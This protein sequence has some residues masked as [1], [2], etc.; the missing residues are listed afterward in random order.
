MGGRASAPR[1]VLLAA[2]SLVVAC[3]S[4]ERQLDKANAR[5]HAGDAKGALAAYKLL[6][7]DLGEGPLPSGD[8]EVR[9][10][11]LRFAGDVSY[12]ELG[13]YQAALSYYRRVVSLAPGGSKEAQE[14]RAVL[15][16]IYRERFKDHLAAIAQYAAI[17]TSDSASAP[18]YQLEVSRGYLA[19]GRFDQAR[20]EARI[21]RERWP[22]D[23]LADEAQLLTGQ[24]WALEKKD[25][26][27]LRA[28][29]ALIDRAP[30]AD[31]KARALEAQAQIQAAAG[32]YDRALELYALALP[33]HPNPDAIRTNIEAVRERREKAKTAR[34]GDRAAAFDQ[35]KVK[36]SARETP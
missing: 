3:S 11:A 12:L 8:A 1:A 17:A 20:T 32:R 26:E 34:P 9:V 36:Q 10:K 4:P 31:V 13:D 23:A 33:T 14:A 7:A 6:L 18:R 5:R 30:R 25:D 19:L 15:G 35:G 27:A 2:L 24:A 16:D 21:L 22:N 29:Q 28:L